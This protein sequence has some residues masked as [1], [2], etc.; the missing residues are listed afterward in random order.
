[1]RFNKFANKTLKQ[2]NINIVIN[3]NTHGIIT[4]E[5]TIFDNIFDDMCSKFE[6]Y[7]PQSMN[8]TIKTNMEAYFKDRLLKEIKT[9]TTAAKSAQQTAKQP[10]K[11]TPFKPI[12]KPSTRFTY[13]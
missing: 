11:P 5:K 3:E 4:P 2:E 7:S 6:V 12:A 8:P 9:L 1:M 10:I 13:H